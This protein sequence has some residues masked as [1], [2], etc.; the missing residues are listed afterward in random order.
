MNKVIILILSLYLVS[1]NSVDHEGSAN[2]NQEIIRLSNYA[3]KNE[4]LEMIFDLDQNIRKNNDAELKPDSKAE[5]AHY[6]KM[7]S[8][9]NLNFKRID[10]YLKTYGYPERDSVSSKALSAPWIVNSSF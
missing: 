5:Q 6:H 3:E 10:L 1:C 7:D 8:I 2:I 4:Y 9:D